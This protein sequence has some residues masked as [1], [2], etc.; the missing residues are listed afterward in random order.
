MKVNYFH[1][2]ILKTYTYATTKTKQKIYLILIL[3]DYKN[4]LRIDLSY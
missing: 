2:E 4:E 3:R 1:S